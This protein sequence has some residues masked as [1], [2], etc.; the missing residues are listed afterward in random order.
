MRSI[1][2]EALDPAGRA[3]RVAYLWVTPF[4]AGQACAVP[5]Q[6]PT[7]D[8]DSY[9]RPQRRVAARELGTRQP[10]D[11]LRSCVTAIQPQ[12]S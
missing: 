3:G 8:G 1:A 4:A 6:S 9:V 11:A 7:I 12:E 2:T 10:A 5:R